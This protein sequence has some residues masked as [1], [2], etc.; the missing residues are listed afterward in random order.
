M[1]TITQEGQQKLDYKMQK[2]TLHVCVYLPLTAFLEIKTSIFA[3]IS[4]N[5]LLLII[6]I[7][8]CVYNDV[9]SKNTPI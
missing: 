7:Y 6:K 2:E 8:V 3:A 1:E 9:F 5:P 4:K